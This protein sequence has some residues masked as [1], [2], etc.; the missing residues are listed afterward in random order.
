MGCP[1]LQADSLPAELPGKKIIKIRVEIKE[2]Q[3]RKAAERTSENRS[4]SLKRATKLMKLLL[5]QRKKTQITKIRNKRRYITI[6]LMDIKRI[7][8]EYY[9]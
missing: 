3:N 1:A 5:E 2:I 4:T 6:T 7:I 9:E 8:T